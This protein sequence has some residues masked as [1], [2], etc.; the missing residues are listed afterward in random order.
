MLGQVFITVIHYLY[1][2]LQF[3]TNLLAGPCGTFTSHIYMFNISFIKLHYK[4]YLKMLQY[5]F[6]AAKTYITSAFN[7]DGTWFF[8]MPKF[9]DDHI[10]ESMKNV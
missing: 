8:N 3:K 9:R 4:H 6:L 1:Y 5:I 2:Y 10:N 7:E